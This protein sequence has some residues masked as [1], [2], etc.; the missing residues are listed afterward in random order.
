MDKYISDFQTFLRKCKK[1]ESTVNLYSGWV[2]YVIKNTNLNPVSLL[3]PEIVKAYIRWI[4]QQKGIDN[5]RTK[6]AFRNFVCFIIESSLERDVQFLFD[7]KI[8]T[9]QEKKKFSY[10]C[11]PLL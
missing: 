2:A 5:S 11:I 6:T 9:E 4:D 3:S 1:A 7:E 10:P 8:L